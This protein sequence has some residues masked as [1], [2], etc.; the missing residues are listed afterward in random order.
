VD[1]KG[2]QIILGLLEQ[3]WKCAMWGLLAK[4]SIRSN[5]GS[6]RSDATSA[7]SL[8]YLLFISQKEVISVNSSYFLWQGKEEKGKG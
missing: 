2:E 4:E 7:R 6:L 3:I 1:S 5:T 8:L